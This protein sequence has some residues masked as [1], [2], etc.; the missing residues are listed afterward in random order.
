MTITTSPGCSWGPS[1][2]SQNASFNCI[3]SGTMT[4]AGCTATLTNESFQADCDEYNQCP[5]TE[6]NNIKQTLT[7]D[8]STWNITTAVGSQKVTG[9]GTCTCQAVDATSN[10]STSATGSSTQAT[11]SAGSSTPSSGSSTPSSGSSTLV[12]TSTA[13]LMLYVVAFSI[14]G[15]M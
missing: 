15:N 14:V 5:F 2:Q 6:I 3:V 12:R 13:L 1:I 8:G 9:T 7:C 11:V 10:S 4:S